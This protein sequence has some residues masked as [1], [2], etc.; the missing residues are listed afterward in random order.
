MNLSTPDADHVVGTEKGIPNA[1]TI[2]QKAEGVQNPS[3]RQFFKE[4]AGGAAA[5]TSLIYGSG[6]DEKG[7]EESDNLENMLTVPENIRTLIE[8]TIKE[9]QTKLGLEEEK[10]SLIFCGYS[11][12]SRTKYSYRT[13]HLE[14]VQLHVQLIANNE[15]FTSVS[16]SINKI[17][18]YSG[19]E[20]MTTYDLDSESIMHCFCEQA[21]LNALLKIRAKKEQAGAAPKIEV[22]N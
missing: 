7:T 15:I 9:T 10:I 14:N 20:T 21:V 11:Y 2:S 4:L 3:R 8:K 19:T 16:N 5:I 1:T 17:N 12:E 18:T 13:S 22:A 6:C